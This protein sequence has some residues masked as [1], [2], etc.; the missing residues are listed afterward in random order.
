MQT[1]VSKRT[2]PVHE[3]EIADDAISFIKDESPSSEGEGGDP[4]SLD[5][6]LL[7]NLLHDLRATV[8]SVRPSESGTS[9]ENSEGMPHREDPLPYAMDVVPAADRGCELCG[10]PFPNLPPD[11]LKGVIIC[12]FECAKR[13]IVEYIAK[14]GGFSVK[15]AK[16]KKALDGPSGT[17]LDS[18]ALIKGYKMLGLHCEFGRMPESH[19]KPGVHPEAQRNTG[20]KRQSCLWRINLTWNREQ[21]FIYVSKT[22]LAHNHAI[23]EPS[24]DHVRFFT[25]V[26]PGEIVIVERMA[27]LGMSRTLII[28]VP[29]HFR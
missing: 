8:A 24:D 19:K 27:L 15:H 17:V 28:K 22:H 2:Q 6:T 10:P 11:T 13:Y 25:D 5:P 7:N 29:P 16:V 21:D 3:Q 12:S 23:L 18:Q 20:S 1:L 9:F 4:G 26:T 14:R